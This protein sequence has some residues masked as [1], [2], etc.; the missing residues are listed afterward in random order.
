MYLEAW[1]DGLMDTVPAMQ[2]EDMSLLEKASLFVP[3]HPEPK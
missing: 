2:I 1:G 3:G